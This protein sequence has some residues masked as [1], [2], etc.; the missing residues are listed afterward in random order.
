MLQNIRDNSRGLI[1]G[2]LIGFLVV[3][4]AISGAETL[5]N[6][7]PIEQSAVKVNGETLTKLDVER[8]IAN[9][10]QQMQERYGDSIPAQFLTDDQLRGPAIDSLIERA[11]LIQAAER[12]GLVASDAELNKAILST[13]AFQN[14]AGVFDPRRYQSLLSNFRYTPSTY[15]K[16][17]GEDSVINQLTAGVVDTGFV[18]PNELDFIISLN[19]QTRDFTYLTL[20][21]DLVRDKVS[22][23]EEDIEAFYSANSASFTQ[24]EQVAVD[25]IELSVDGLIDSIEVSEETLRQ[26]YA[27]NLANFQKDPQFHVA[28]ILIESNDEAKIKE[29]S[30]KLAQGES[31][32]EVARNFSD[33]LGSKE[34]GGD[35]G[36]ATASDFPDSFA[37]ALTALAVGEVSAAVKTDAGTHFI[38]KIAEQ[39][40]EPPSFEDE[41][42]RLSYQIRRE[43][44]ESQFA[45]LLL[46]LKDLSY[47]AEALAEVAT[48]LGLEAKNTGL[49][50]RAGGQGI[51]AQSAFVTAAFSEEVLVDGNASDVIEL[52][53]NRVVVLKKTQFKESYLRPLEEVREDIV[54][55][56]TVTKTQE[57]LAEQAQQIQAQVEAG[58]SLQA[59]AE[60][61]Q[62]EFAEHQKVGRSYPSVNPQLLQQVFAMSGPEDGKPHVK[63]L[64]LGQDG[65][66]VVALTAVHKDVDALP[67]DQR[68]A[69]AMQLNSVYGRSELR[70]LQA[71]LHEVAKIKR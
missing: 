51:A 36:Y 63:A 3:L 15:K 21:A 71:Y 13:P 68:Q 44:A 62:L 70:G 32:E 5:F 58:D 45:S 29:V 48:E 28:H 41:R 22:I 67:Q 34:D 17:I 27:Q 24:P 42:E 7:D 69:I 18:S 31:F 65:Y 4:F 6:R 43:S 56:L 64:P 52:T 47:N 30:E 33:D 61:Q 49:I 11:L 57:L 66:A 35:L 38:K 46:R 12:A 2:I 26:Q 39:G 1:S 37:S 50:S 23:S 10:R 54:A 55:S 59:I 14:E 60:E 19:F 8:A 40:V 9:R 25:Y 20:N 53:P 16:A